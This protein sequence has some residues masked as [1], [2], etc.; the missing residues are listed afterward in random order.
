MTTYT[1][2]PIDDPFGP[3]GTTLPASMTR[4][5][6][7]GSDSYNSLK[8]RLPLQWRPLHPA[9]RS[10]PGPGHHCLRHQRLDEIV[11]S[12]TNSSGLEQG[13]V[14]N[15]G[16]YFTIDDPSGTKGT[17]LTGINN[18]GAAVGYYFDSS[19]AA[20]GFIFDLAFATLNG[21]RAPQGPKR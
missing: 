10:G 19:G 17:V 13:F 9:Q 11:G 3:Q 8:T 4:A 1:F 12:Y 15:S 18:S 5:R 20:H 16:T 7:S 21:P 2:S 6:S 14:W